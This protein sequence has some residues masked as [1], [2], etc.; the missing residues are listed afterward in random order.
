MKNNFNLAFITGASSGIG[1]AIARLLASKGINLILTGRNESRLKDL[2]DSL[3]DKVQV[4]IISKDLS[5]IEDRHD[6]IKLIHDRVPD[7]F[8]NNAGMGKY[9]D[10]LTRTTE[11]QMEMFHLNMTALTELSIEAARSLATAGK[12]GV[13]FNVSSVAA[14]SPFPGFSI[15]AA[16]KAYVNSFSEAFDYELQS[17]GIR[18]LTI[19]PGQVATRFQQRSGL[20]TSGKAPE[21]Q[22]M[23]TEKIA[24]EIWAQIEK[25]QPIRVVDWKYRLISF[26]IEYFIPKKLLFKTLHKTM[27]LRSPNNTL[28]KTNN[29]PKSG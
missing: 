10:I 3:S 9:G 16:S 18:V 28:I 2:A 6:L 26:L 21:W 13:I 22:V 8:I 14:F 11:E 29:G 7:L 12:Q 20:T 17:Q 4:E 15:Y 24:N 25:S 23:S 1:E 19:C 27:H 5:I